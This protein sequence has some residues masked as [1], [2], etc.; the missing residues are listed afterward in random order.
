MVE[1]HGAVFAQHPFCP[2]D[3]RTVD[4]NMNRAKCVYGC[5]DG[6]LYIVFAGNIRAHVANRLTQISSDS[7]PARIIQVQK[8]S[9][10]T[11]RHQ[12][13][14]GGLAQ[15]RCTTCNERDCSINLHK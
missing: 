8:N 2:A 5:F 9:P 3:A 1:R 4:H 12:L 13:T 10:R 14:K 7:L 6:R 15:P 11:A